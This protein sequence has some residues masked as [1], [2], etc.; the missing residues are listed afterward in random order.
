MIE[1][2]I[3]STQVTSET[4]PTIIEAIASPSFGEC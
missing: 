3:P 2:T 1:M 4:M